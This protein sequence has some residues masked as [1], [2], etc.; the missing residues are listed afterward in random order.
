MAGGIIQLLYRGALDMYI[1]GNPE[2][3]FFKTVFRR[4]TRFSLEI[5]ENNFTDDP[6]FGTKNRTK[7]Y[8]LGDLITDMVMR[9]RLPEVV[10]EEG[11]MFAWTNNIGNALLECVR[12]EIGGQIMDRM[13]G[14]WLQIWYELADNKNKKH[15]VAHNVMIGN[16]SNLTGY[17]NIDKPQ[18]DLFIPLYFWF[19]RYIGTALPILGLHYHDTYVVV[20][21]T[22]LEKLCIY[23]ETFLNSDKLAT[24]NIQYAA[25]RITYAYISVEERE[26]FLDN[27]NEYLIEQI[28]YNG[29]DFSLTNKQFYRL[30]FNYP[31][32][33][34]IWFLQNGNFITNKK[35]LCYTSTN[36]NIS[37]INTIINSS[38]QL[39][40]S[41]FILLLS[42]DIITGDDGNDIII[43]DGETLPEDIIQPELYMQ[44][45]KQ[46]E[47][48]IGNINIINNSDDLAFWFN[49][50]SL[51]LNNV[52]LMDKISATI[53]ITDENDVLITNLTTTIDIT[54]ISVPIVNMVDTRLK[55]DDVYVNLFNNYG[56][57]IDRSTS[58]ITTSALWLDSVER[59]NE[60]G[61]KFFNYLQPYLHHSKV[62]PLGLHNYNFCINPEEL[63]PSGYINFSH[64]KKINLILKISNEQ[65]KNRD[66]IVHIFDV[67]YNVLRVGNGL[68]GI[69]YT[70]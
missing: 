5:H 53:T 8:P 59:V 43:S 61:T 68:A 27:M 58:P 2:I 35:F 6:N 70:D 45:I 11:E 52:S 41:S 66:S 16:T 37:W 36:T 33:E 42:P 34:L 39:I 28:Q 15:D 49:Y 64:I 22:E 62:P 25:V 38:E 40:R 46:T 7:V 18:K 44:I 32:K 10:L 12:L 4:Y 51:L 31:S 30:D 26:R 57:Y 29:Q 65:V 50:N 21:F 20:D 19:S 3:T 63:Q 69:A 54:D 24:L 60:R 17:N 13:Y 48:Q 55:S 23:N 47:T 1:L 9:V 14:I 67:N 56:S